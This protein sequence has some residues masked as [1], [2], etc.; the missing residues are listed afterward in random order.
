MIAVHLLAFTVITPLLLLQLALYANTMEAAQYKFA[1]AFEL[2]T[3][4]RTL[5]RFAQITY[6]ESS[7]M[8]LL[9]ILEFPDPQLRTRAKPVAVDSRIHRG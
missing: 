4:N 6:S 9:T 8:A 3:P 7:Y 5:F 2:T 1:V